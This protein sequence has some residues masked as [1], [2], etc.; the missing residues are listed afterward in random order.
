MNAGRISQR[1]P[2][3]GRPADSIRN[4]VPEV[5]LGTSAKKD[6]ESEDPGLN[7]ATLALEGKDSVFMDR[8][9][10]KVGKHKGKKAGDEWIVY[11]WEQVKILREV[12]RDPVP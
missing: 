10:C 5:M 12:P 8:G 2:K 1:E 9:L 6:R 7:F 11:S 3:N 4:S